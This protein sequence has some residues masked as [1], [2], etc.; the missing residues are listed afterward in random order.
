MSWIVHTF[1]VNQNRLPTTVHM[2]LGVGFF[3]D[4]SF[5]Q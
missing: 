5:E 4:Y 3:V 1:K 2:K